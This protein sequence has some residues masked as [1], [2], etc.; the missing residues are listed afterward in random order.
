M[1][2]TPEP[3]ADD[4]RPLD[5]IRAALGEGADH[6]VDVAEAIE[7]LATLE[8]AREVLLA[9]VEALEE[10]LPGEAALTAALARAQGAFPKIE[11]RNTAEVRGKDG[12]PGYSYSYADLGDVLAAVRPVLAEHG[13]AV[14]QRTQPLDGGK[15]RL[16]TEL[17][18][19]AGGLLDSETEIGTPTTN[20]QQF[21]GTLTYLRRYELVTLLG[22]AAEEDRDAQDVEPPARAANGRGR[23]LPAW[24]RVATPAEAEAAR[25]GLMALFRHEPT[26]DEYLARL[27]GGTD[28]ALTFAA[29]AA[30]SHVRD[31]AKLA[32]DRLAGDQRAAQDADAE[33]PDEAPADEPPP[34]VGMSSADL[35]AD[36]PPPADDRPAPGTVETPERP[37]GATDEEYLAILRAAGCTCPNLDTIADACP[38]REHGIPF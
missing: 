32:R 18:H 12:K 8:A 35:D 2:S 27:A 23:E 3:A 26:V 21:G 29:A 1:S 10:D 30:V 9:R 13:I 16:L 17:R 7:E 6:G 14:V 33:A 22:I 24:A 19:V 20:P 11:R 4:A 31:W 15:T 36:V 25:T 38:L 37:D 28:G 34:G 5:P